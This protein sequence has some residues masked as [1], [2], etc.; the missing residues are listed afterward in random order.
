MGMLFL[1]VFKYIPMAGIL[2]AFKNYSISSNIMTIFT[3]K[4]VGLKYFREFVNDADFFMIVRNTFAL[5]IL[6]IVFTFPLPIL[7]AIMIDEV[8]RARIKRFAQTVSYLPH[9]ISWVIVSGMIYTFFSVDGGVINNM[10]VWLGVVKEP[11]SFIVN[12]KYFWGLAVA[13]DAWKEFGW[14]SII[15]LA[16]IASID[17][18]LFE[19]AMIDGAGRLARIWHITLPSIMGAVGIVMILSIG[20]LISGGVS[21]SN[22]DQSYLLGNALNKETSLIIQTYT[23]KVGLEQLRYSFAAAVG[24]IQSIISVTLLFGGNRLSR[25]FLGVSLY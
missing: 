8:K 4:W 3:S 13:T 6:K 14:W 5:S 1:F 15:F 19:A 25:K 9:F 12:P 11:V 24:L 10:L 17:P 2:M 23:L 21:G 16:A 20:N 18:T 22:F 7:F